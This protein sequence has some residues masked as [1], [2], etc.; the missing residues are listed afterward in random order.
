MPVSKCS[1][2][3]IEEY[4]ARGSQ[5]KTDRLWRYVTTPPDRQLCKVASLNSVMAAWQGSECERIQFQA[6]CYL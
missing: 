1:G 4:F 6:L 5:R 3:L 2:K